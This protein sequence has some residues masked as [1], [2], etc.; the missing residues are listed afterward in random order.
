MK[1][2]A[3]PKLSP[4]QQEFLR[5]VPP[6][7]AGRFEKAFLGEGSPRQAIRTKCLECSGFQRI[8]AAACTVKLCPLW[9]FNS[10]RGE[11][12]EPGDQAEESQL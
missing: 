1:A 3:T 4:T 6:M 12:A 10:W 5:N 2:P 8:E 9:A 11:S 7:Y